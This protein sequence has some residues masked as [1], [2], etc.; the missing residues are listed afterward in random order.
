M[1]GMVVALVK[2]CLDS[3]L[4]VVLFGQMGGDLIHD[5]LNHR[6]GGLLGEV[7]LG[8]L[9]FVTLQLL[10]GLGVDVIMLV[11]DMLELDET[12]SGHL[13]QVMLFSQILDQVIT[14]FDQDALV[15]EPMEVLDICGLNSLECFVELFVELVAVVDQGW[16]D[17]GLDELEVLSISINLFVPS[18]GWRFRR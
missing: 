15:S 6:L 4:P 8:D 13:F 1:D 18:F 7:E 16:Q 14:E 10:L 17:L 5:G 9:L 11:V 12:D 2:N 3:H